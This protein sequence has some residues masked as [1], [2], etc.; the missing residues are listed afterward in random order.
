MV[1]LQNKVLHAKP[2]SSEADL[3]VAKIPVAM[4]RIPAILNK[5]CS[6]GKSKDTLLGL[7]T[8]NGMNDKKNDYIWR[9]S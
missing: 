3:P 4:V 9:H 1:T 6:C 7:D 8:I 2:T 5:Y